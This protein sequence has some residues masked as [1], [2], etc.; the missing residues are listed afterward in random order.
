MAESDDNLEMTEQTCQRIWILNFPLDFNSLVISDM[1]EIQTC[2]RGQ[3]VTAT[4]ETE[5]KA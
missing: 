4:A 2:H 3:V 1:E 5:E